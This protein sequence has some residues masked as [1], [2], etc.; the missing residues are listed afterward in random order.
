MLYS[1]NHLIAIEENEVLHFLDGD[2]GYKIE[3]GDIAASDYFDS[4]DGY[5]LIVVDNTLIKKYGQIGLDYHYMIDQETYYGED[6]YFVYDQ[7]VGVGNYN[8]VYV[9][10][11]GVYQDIDQG[12]AENLVSC[13]G[14][15]YSSWQS[16]WIINDY[17]RPMFFILD[18]DFK[19]QSAVLT[20]GLTGLTCSEDELYAKIETYDEEGFYIGTEYVRL[21]IET[22]MSQEQPLFMEYKQAMSEPI[23]NIFL[24]IVPLLGFAQY[25]LEK[26]KKVVI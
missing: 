10:N 4:S 21:D 16:N 5:E 24:Y 11:K 25:T 23:K 15:Y 6:I 19:I 2:E 3:D 13:N 12:L 17:P 14:V 26:K 8:Q 20:T 7:N 1:G 18:K 9:S 22:M